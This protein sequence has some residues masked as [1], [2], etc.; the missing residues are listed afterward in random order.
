M[1]R[2]TYPSDVSDEAWAL[3]HPLVP[4]ADEHPGKQPADRREIV[5]AI[6]YVVRT[7]GQWRYLPHDLPHWR[8]VYEYFSKWSADGT[9]DRIEQALRAKARRASKRKPKTTL[10]IIDSQTVKTTE[11]GGPRGYDGNKK[12]LGRKR[13]LVV[14]SIG[15][16]ITHVHT[17]ANVHDSK[18]AHDLVREAKRREPKIKTMIGDQAYRGRPLQCTA[19]AVGVRMEVVEPK[20]RLSKF[21]PVKHRWKVERTLA[22]HGR[23]RRLSKDVERTIESSEG[24]MAVASIGILLRRCTSNSPRKRSNKL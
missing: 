2:P 17:P 12:T 13:N 18:P 22:W 9:W 5:N 10:A 20:E 14:D 6:F 3:L 21:V 8:T 16:P 4:E 15:L 7:G 11:S 19:A 1:A 24:A 23:N